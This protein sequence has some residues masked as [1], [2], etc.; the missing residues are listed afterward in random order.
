MT[1]FDYN[2]LSSY[3]EALHHYESYEFKYCTRAIISRGL[4]YFTPSFTAVYNQDQLRLET[5]YVVDNEF[6]QKNLRFITESSFQIK[7]GL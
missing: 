2:I 5:I 3:L 4:Y 7:S 6:L 1:D